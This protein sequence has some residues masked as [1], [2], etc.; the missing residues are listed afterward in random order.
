MNS[1]RSFFFKS[2]QAQ[3]AKAR[4]SATVAKAPGR[5]SPATCLQQSWRSGNSKTVSKKKAKQAR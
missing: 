3:R 2:P 1:L 5:S 4:V